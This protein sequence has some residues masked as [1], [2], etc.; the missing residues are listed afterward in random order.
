MRGWRGRISWW[1]D[2]TPLLQKI[3]THGNSDFIAREP[4][5]RHRSCRHGGGRCFPVGICGLASGSKD[6]PHR[7][8]RKPPPVTFHAGQAKSLPICAFARSEGILPAC[9]LRGRMPAKIDF[10]TERRCAPAQPSSGASL[11]VATTREGAL[12]VFAGESRRSRQD[13]SLRDGHARFSKN[14]NLRV[15]PFACLDNV[16]ASTPA[17]LCPKHHPAHPNNLPPM[18]RWW[19]FRCHRNRSR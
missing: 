16:G 6:S 4:H 10:C 5:P 1:M 17:E 7:R 9:F 13:Q 19:L 15:S 3:P 11:A 8:G 14:R 18:R 2:W 12:P